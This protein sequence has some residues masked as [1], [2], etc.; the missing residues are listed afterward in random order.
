MSAGRLRHFCTYFDANYF[1]RGM[2]LLLSLR[3]HA[4]RPFVLHVLAL[5]DAVHEILSQRAW[6]DVDVVPL[7]RLEE[8]DPL[9][10]ATKEDRRR[11]EYI[12]TLTGCFALWLLERR[13]D[14]DLLT[15]LDADTFF[16]GDP[17]AVFAEIGDADVAITPHRFHDRNYNLKVHGIFN[18]GWISWRRS[19]NGLRCLRDYRRDCLHWCHDYVDGTRFADQRYLDNWPLAYPNVRVIEHPGVNLAPWNLD[20]FPLSADGPTVGERPL[21]LYHYHKFGMTADGRWQPNIASYVRDPGRVDAAALE[22]I[23]RP[24]ARVLRRIAPP[25]WPRAGL[26]ARAAEAAPPHPSAHLPRWERMA[27]WIDDAEVAPG[28]ERPA[29]VDGFADAYRATRRRRTTAAP[30]AGDLR[31]QSDVF[32]LAT[33]AARAGPQARI[34]D[35]GG[36]VGTHAEALRLLLPGRDIQYWCHDLPAMVARGRA[37]NAPATFT[38]DPAVALAGRYDVVCAF[39]SLHYCRDWRGVLD[40]L[41]QAT[42]QRLLLAHLPLVF[43]VPG[44]AMIHRLFDHRF[45]TAFAC[46]TLNYDEVLATAAR[47]GLVL[48]RQL[49]SSGVTYCVG[50]PEHFEAMTL[51]FGRPDAA[52]EVFQDA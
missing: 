17:E 32:A 12:F 9:A 48:E 34:L 15:Y 33:V 41:C 6:R 11:A 37:L 19:E 16:F 7:S 49:L 31:R 35:W 39:D 29:V 30:P 26:G 36:G 43:S 40:G 5:D 52:R 1:S 27:D 24:Y 47:H 10:A 2:A 13:S 14:I 44:Y 20:T 46:W 51:V 38:D 8:D 50:A 28:W 22:A 45:R 42:G 23:Y 21:I 25:G 18:V 3:R 4:T